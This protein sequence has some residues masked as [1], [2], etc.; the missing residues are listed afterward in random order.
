MDSKTPDIAQALQILDEFDAFIEA[1][2]N[3]L[4]GGK[5]NFKEEDLITFN[6]RI[7]AALRDERFFILDD[8]KKKPWS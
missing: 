3:A 4:F 8:E 5:K 7:R 2:P 1:A 6:L